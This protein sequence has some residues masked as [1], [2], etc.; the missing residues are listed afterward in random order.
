MKN[1]S[2]LKRITSLLLTFVMV[3]TLMPDVILSSIAAENAE[4]TAIGK[5]ADPDSFD[6]WKDYYGNNS[7]LPDGSRGVS[8]WKAG[9]VW[10]DKSVYTDSS[11]F[12]NS[13]T[14]DNQA[15]NFLVALSALASTDRPS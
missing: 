11:K 15:D 4:L 10:T 3:I 9:G 14:M 13:V 7:L 12:P 5:V 8:T 6:N 2:F 1:T